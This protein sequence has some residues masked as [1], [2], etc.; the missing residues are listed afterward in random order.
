MSMADCILITGGAGFIGSFL[1]DHFLALGD[2]VRILDN[3]DPQV[4]PGGRPAWCHRD[5]ELIE[6]DVRDKSAV[7]SALEGVDV[8]IHC[9]AA[10]GVGQ[11]LYRIRHYVDT[12]VTGTATLLEAMVERRSP[13]KKLLVPTS[14]TSYGEGV[15]RRPSDGAL[16]RI[17]V[18]SEEEVRRH[19]W[20]P[21]DPT[22]GERLEPVPTREDAELRARSVYALTKRYQEELATSLGRVY[23]IPV[24]CL[25]LF[26][27]F[28]PRQALSNPYTGVLAIFLSRLLSGRGLV[29]Y[30]DGLQ[31]RDFVS[32]HD[33]VAAFAA[34]I[35][36]DHVSNHVLN[37]GTGV[38]RTIAGVAQEVADFVGVTL[39]LEGTSGQFR[40]GDVRH[41]F[42]DIGLARRLLDFAPGHDFRGRLA[43]IVAWSE[44]ATTAAVALDPDA[45]L[46][47]RGLIR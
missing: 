6:A 25:R 29:L 38:P 39:K 43:E 45:E 20:E 46:R 1:A 5:V 7:A 21:V 2:D 10:V 33:V 42:A 12:N 17:D 34:A 24:A 41:C 32:V 9:A 26:N 27:V 36:S 31:T 15:Y 19:G 35:A 3:L 8:V 40:V 37:V 28:G 16:L 44:T 4:H 18:R 13:F 22:S 14:M 23:G 47:S 30:E 11:A